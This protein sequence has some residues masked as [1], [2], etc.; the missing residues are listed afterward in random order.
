M[1]LLQEDAASPGLKARLEA[2]ASRV[3]WVRA[4]PGHA[5]AIERIKA[6][7]LASGY[8]PSADMQRYVQ[9]ISARMA[10]PVEDVQRALVAH[11]ALYTLDDR[12][13]QAWRETPLAQD[14]FG[15]L[16]I[17]LDRANG[18]YDAEAWQKDINLAL[19][20][21]VPCGV[22]LADSYG[23]LRWRVVVGSIRR[24]GR[25]G[26]ALDYIGWRGWG[27][28]YE[29]HIDVRNLSAFSPAGWTI[30]YRAIADLLRANPHMRGTFASS[31][32]FDPH[33]SAISPELG[34][35]VDIPKKGGATFMRNRPQPIDL[36]WA[37]ARSAARQRA[38]K[39]GVYH[40]TSYT[41]VWPRKALL[42]W[43]NSAG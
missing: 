16:L 25:P 13:G 43:S 6:R 17:Y 27:R 18:R 31:W 23:R 8:C 21:S 37:T 1:S 35:L 4:D 7:A 32:F 11:C 20:L 42:D 22:V 10:L 40:P 9:D 5:S 2:H 38:V 12:A 30:A 15:R 26:L 14:A 41:M 28:W 24:F 19:G 39:E 29:P 33:L 34:Y 3:D 36:A